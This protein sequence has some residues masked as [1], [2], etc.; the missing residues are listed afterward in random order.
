M[1]YNANK[2]TLYLWF[3]TDCNFIYSRNYFPILKKVKKAMLP[4]WIKKR[5]LWEREREIFRFG[6]WGREYITAMSIKFDF[7]FIL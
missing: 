3:A 7:Y 2:K 6:Q 4:F 1:E 5:I